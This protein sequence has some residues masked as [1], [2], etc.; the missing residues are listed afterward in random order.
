M[1]LG[2]CTEEGG[3]SAGTHVIIW[4]RRPTTSPEAHGI[5]RTHWGLGRPLGHSPGPGLLTLVRCSCLAS[6][7]SCPEGHFCASL[8]GPPCVNDHV[9]L[10]DQE[11]P[12][13]LRSLKGVHDKVQTQ[14]RHP[15]SKASFT[16]GTKHHNAGT[17]IVH[18]GQSQGPDMRKQWFGLTGSIAGG[19][20][21]LLII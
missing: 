17:Q 18:S 3:S 14:A 5:S 16:Q 13:M 8:E 15:G 12:K 6:G 2:L 11:E 20:M 4:L 21:R 19:M 1:S 7:Q 10:R 9:P